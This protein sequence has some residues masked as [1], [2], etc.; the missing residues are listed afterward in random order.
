M[1]SS[2][3]HAIGWS[4]FDASRFDAVACAAYKWL[5]SPRGTAF[6]A[7]SDRAFEQTPPIA[8]NWFAGEDRYS[9]YD[10][11]LRLADDAR[12]IDAG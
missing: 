9:Y 7:L 10:R 12:R 3:T 4:P 5:M 1:P 2:P 11:E 6:L 8:A